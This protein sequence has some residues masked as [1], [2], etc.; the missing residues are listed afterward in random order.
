M[1]LHWPKLEQTIPSS[2][3]PRTHCMLLC[4]PQDK[5]FGHGIGSKTC[6]MLHHVVNPCSSRSVMPKAKK[7]HTRITHVLRGWCKRLAFPPLQTAGLSFPANVL[8]TV[9]PEK[10]YRDCHLPATN[11]HGRLP[12]SRLRVPGQSRDC[13]SWILTRADSLS[14]AG[15]PTE[16]RS[17]GDPGAAMVVGSG[18]KLQVG[19]QH[20]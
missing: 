15:A 17:G 5:H 16:E 11:R 2:R 19:A 8:D 13:P 3:L 14:A 9:D 10:L 7:R 12:K 1:I 4:S 20:R 18:G 6:T